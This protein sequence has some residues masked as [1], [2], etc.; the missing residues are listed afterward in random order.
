MARTPLAVVAR[1]KLEPSHHD[2]LTTT[3]T[4]RLSLYDSQPDFS[5][6]L[7]LALDRQKE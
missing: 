3:T 1:H 7:S 5:L 2:P 6:S 4:I